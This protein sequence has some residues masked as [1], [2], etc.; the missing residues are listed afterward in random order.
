[1]MPRKTAALSQRLHLKLTPE[2]RRAIATVA[3]RN[4][5]STNA[6]IRLAIHDHVNRNLRRRPRVAEQ[7]E[8]AY[9]AEGKR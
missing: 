7:I 3:A 5:R 1:M 6:E 4:E 2:L 9:A 8:A